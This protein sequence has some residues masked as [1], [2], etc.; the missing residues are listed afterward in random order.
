MDGSAIG[1]KYRLLVDHGN[2]AFSPEGGVRHG[3][4]AGAV[5]TVVLEVP[6]A[7]QGAHNTEEDAYVLEFDDEALSIGPD[8][9][10]VRTPTSR[11]VSYDLRLFDPAVPNHTFELVQ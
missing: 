4:V 5:G 6:A 3:L 9:A 7:E 8:A 11:R 10:V 1:R 2:Q